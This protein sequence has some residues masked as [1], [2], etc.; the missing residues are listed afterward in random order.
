MNKGEL[1]DA[2]ATKLGESKA[3]TSRS[4]EAILECITLGVKKD[5]NVTLVGFG[6]FQKRKRGA[7]TGRNPSTGEMIRIKESVTVGFKPSQTLKS[8]L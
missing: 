2:V 7:R 5:E 3:A 6:T 8:T 4:L 1:I